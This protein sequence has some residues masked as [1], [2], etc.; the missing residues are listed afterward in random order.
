MNWKVNL[1]I[2]PYKKGFSATNACPRAKYGVLLVNVGSPRSPRFKD[3]WVYLKEFL[4]DK[5]V[6][7]LPW[8]FRVLLLFC[9]IL[10][11]RTRNSARLYKNI[12]TREGS[13]LIVLSEKLRLK[14]E[15]LLGE[16]FVVRVGMRYQEPSLKNALHDFAHV[17][18]VVLLP[19]FPQYATA[20][21]G[22]VFEK[23]TKIINQNWQIPPLT[24][25]GA[26]YNHPLFISCFSEAIQEKISNFNYDFILFSYHGLPERHIKKCNAAQG[27]VFTEECCL[28]P[29]TQNKFCYRAQC[30]QTT[31]LIAKQLGLKKYGMAFQSRLGR[32]KWIEPY[33]DK[34]LL[35]LIQKGVRNL[36]VTCPSFVTDCLETL[37]EIALRA[38]CQW[39]AL[40][41]HEL[42]LVE[43]L[44]DRDSWA[45]AVATM[46]REATS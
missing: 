21:T 12:W 7:D 20:S 42:V 25:M 18:R 41:G 17:E 22:T 23:V 38:R 37:D 27:C 33:T 2:G 45:E 10:P 46:V 14:V 43:S 4:S 35:E 32:T 3:V 15:R 13:P 34:I 9:V 28:A 30:F 39:I 19:L 11:F 31:E 29:V 1:K 24:E 44:N 8:F 16:N 5:R 6:I 26:F 36:V 40:G